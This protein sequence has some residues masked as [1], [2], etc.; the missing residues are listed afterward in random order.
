[1]S[2]SIG[3]THLLSIAFTLVFGIPIGFVLGSHISADTLM[4]DRKLAYAEARFKHAETV[5]GTL[6]L[7]RTGNA[8]EAIRWLD[9]TAE[10]IRTELRGTNAS[11]P[12]EIRHQYERGVALIDHYQKEFEVITQDGDRRGFNF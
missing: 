11:M 7:L 3:R 6:R 5:V 9:T 2:R 4:E 12:P 8:E 1:M 10:L